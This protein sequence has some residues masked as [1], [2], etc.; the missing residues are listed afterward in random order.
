MC[1]Q[2]SLPVVPDNSAASRGDNESSKSEESSK[3]VKKPV[4]SSVGTKKS[5][6]VLG[7]PRPPASVKNLRL[8]PPKKPDQKVHSSPLFS[9]YA[10][11]Q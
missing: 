5:P 2:P 9:P 1:A 7:G 11:F 4:V 8:Q 3:K 10:A 6:L